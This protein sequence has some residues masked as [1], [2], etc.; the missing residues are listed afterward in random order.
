MGMKRMYGREKSRHKCVCMGHYLPKVLACGI[1]DLA[2]RQ[3]LAPLS[4]GDYKNELDWQLVAISCGGWMLCW[5]EVGGF[6][7]GSV[8]PPKASG[9]TSLGINSALEYYEDIGGVYGCI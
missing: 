6:G 7:C 1:L 4:C 9:N 3:L 2:R 5:R 8:R